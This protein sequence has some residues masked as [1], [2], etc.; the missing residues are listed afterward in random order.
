MNL[1]IKT[2]EKI[3]LLTCLYM[4]QSL[5]T[6]FF[7]Q[8]IPVFLRQQG[9]S[10][11]TIGL[12][13][14]LI[15]PQV[16]RFLWAPWIDRYGRTTTGHYK[17]WIVGAQSAMV[18]LLIVC[19]GFNLQTD[20]PT[21]I[22]ILLVLYIAIATQDIA[23]DALAIGLL[24]QSERGIGNGIQV[25][26]S[27][28]G[29]VLGGGVLLLLL[30]NLGW[31]K[32][33]VNLAIFI[34]ILAMPIY[35]HREQIAPMVDPRVNKWGTI[36]SFL[37]LR[38]NRDWLLAIW[39]F[40][41][42]MGMTLPMVQA[43]LVDRGWSLTEIGMLTGIVGQTLSCVSA[44]AAGAIATMLGIH[45]SIL[46]AQGFAMCAISLQ[47]WLAAGASDKL[48]IYAIVL[49]L[50]VAISMA[51]TAM[52]AIMMARVRP[53]S[54]GT[55]FSI[56]VSVLTIG[57]IGIG[58]SLGGTIASKLGYSGLFTISLLVAAIGIWLTYRWLDRELPTS[59]T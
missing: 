58:G 29:A 44:L 9:V 6:T 7:S 12:L 27:S 21:I 17:F 18:V 52:Y 35:L 33:L 24:D 8:T 53:D 10:L 43:L 54:A 28:L 16:L 56:Q 4:S 15:F 19:A 5:P 55:D 13:S 11:E 57:G 39:I 48:A 59:A 1:N 30:E 46:L 51:I 40:G 31:Q 2:I 45:R 41:M 47:L 42:S 25:G 20:L 49:S 26:A 36:G 3:R 50:E 37:T 23:T 32:S 34:A 14:L 22:A 38:S